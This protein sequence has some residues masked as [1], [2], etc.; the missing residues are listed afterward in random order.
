MGAMMVKKG[1]KQD[2][3]KP[4]NQFAVIDQKNQQVGQQTNVVINP[5][6]HVPL[7]AEGANFEALR[8][9]YLSRVFKQTCDLELSGIDPKAATTEACQKMQL[10]AVYTGLLTRQPEIDAEKFAGSARPG[11]AEHSMTLSA[12]ALLNREKYLVLLGDPGS[13]KSTFINFVALCLAGEKMGNLLANIGVMRAPLPFEEDETRGDKRK[14][15][16]RQ[17]WDHGPLLPVRI[18]LRDLAARGLSEPGAAANRDTLWKFIGAELGN[19]LKEFA[20]H[21]KKVLQEEGG[22]ILLD[23]LDEVPDASNRRIQVKEAVKGFVEDFPKCRVLATSRTYAYQRQEWKLDGFAEAL[24]SPFSPKQ[25][26][27]FVEKW[28]EHIGH[29]RNLNNEEA[30]GRASLL[31]TAIERSERLAELAERPLLLTLMASLHAWRGGSLPEK[32]EQLYADA[33]ELLLDQWESPKVVRDASGQPILQQSSIAEWLRVD[34]SVVRWELNQLAFEAHRDQPQLVGTADIS[35]ERLVA[36]L[37]RIARNKEVNPLQIEAYIRDRAGLLAARGDGVYTFPHR[38]FQEYLAACHLTDFGF[39]DA[40]ADLLRADPQRWREAVLLAGSKAARGT[41]AAA[42]FLAEALCFREVA[43]MKDGGNFDADCWGA[44]LAGQT[45]LENER[46]RLGQVS[47]RNAPRLKRFRQWLLLIVV[48][49]LLPPVDRALAGECLSVFGDARDLEELV[50][51]PE[52]K[53]F[54]GN[55][56]D[57]D[58]R[59]K[60]EVFLPGFKIGRYPVTNS[61]YRAFINATGRTWYFSKGLR[62]EY[63][64]CPA[65]S[66]E[67]YDARAFCEW[68]TVEWRKAGRIFGD[69]IVRLPTEAEW[70]KAARGTGGRD[71]PWGDSWEE[72]RC[73]TSESK[74]GGTCAVGMFPGGASP[75]GCLDMAGNVWEWTSSL[76]GKNF[77]KPDFKYPYRPDDGRENLDAGNE[78][79]RVLRGG[80]WNRD[81]YFARCAGRYWDCPYNWH[82]YVGFRV[83]VSPISP[84]SAL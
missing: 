65:E 82:D 26:S 37:M 32:R 78:I 77:G 17:P 30:K 47:E 43:V 57:K 36:D 1:K 69:E 54:M 24:L 79:L 11:R 44:L 72:G 31:I 9:S 68:L 14:E 19:N 63:A 74:I 75:Y 33:V 7:S 38:T 52:G 83:V 64:N 56:R 25:I 6:T 66:V 42:W 20:P 73:N 34:K 80:S 71:Y 45:L 48:E 5:V 28:Y 15:K 29:V 67:W 84:P 59:P 35:Q 4:Q 18:V 58:A 41:S 60:H 76:W 40:A 12:L 51:V 62:P 23:G 2:P 70:E 21:L 53:F 49:G 22:L 10:S 16:R 3:R 27:H 13:G 46:E 39:P 61:Q 81:Q 55:D 50:P 8:E